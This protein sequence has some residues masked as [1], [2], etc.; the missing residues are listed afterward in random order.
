MELSS[1]F[2]VL[3]RRSVS[4]SNV[5]Q[6]VCSTD[7]SVRHQGEQ[8]ASTLCL[9]G[10]GSMDDKGGRLLHGLESVGSLVHI[11]TNKPDFEGVGAAPAL[12]GSASIGD[13]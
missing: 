6:G 12:S 9:T 11:S 13:P 1:S 10:P 5:S 3:F 4:S 2:G 7:R 8:V